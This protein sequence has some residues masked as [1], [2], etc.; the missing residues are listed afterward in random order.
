[1]GRADLLEFKDGG[2]RGNRTAD[3]RIFNGVLQNF[4]II[5]NRLNFKNSSVLQNVLGR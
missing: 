1:M 3:T 4:L 5:F 2:Q